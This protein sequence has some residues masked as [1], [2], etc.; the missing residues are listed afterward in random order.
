MNIN[1]MTGY[2]TVRDIWHNL[3]F[4]SDRICLQAKKNESMDKVMN[5][6]KWVLQPESSEDLPVLATENTNIWAKAVKAIFWFTVSI[7]IGFL[8]AQLGS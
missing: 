2:T 6:A 3:D 5:A 4:Y 8:I 7:A 1:H